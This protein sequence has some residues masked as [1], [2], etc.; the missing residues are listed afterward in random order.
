MSFL[1]KHLGPSKLEE[2]F[3]KAINLKW[4]LKIALTTGAQIQK[5]HTAIKKIDNNNPSAFYFN[6]E[7]NNLFIEGDIFKEVI[8]SNYFAIARTNNQTDKI[9]I[10]FSSNNELG[11]IVMKCSIHRKNILFEGTLS[12]WNCNLQNTNFLLT[13]LHYPES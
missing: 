1:T 2:T 8:S 13:T 7:M 5:D 11:T 9:E 10:Y 6:F 4:E 12:N 3:K